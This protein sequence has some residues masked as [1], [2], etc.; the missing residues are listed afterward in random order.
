M[1]DVLKRLKNAKETLEKGFQKD[2]DF[3]KISIYN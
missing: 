3:Y 1:K 2:N